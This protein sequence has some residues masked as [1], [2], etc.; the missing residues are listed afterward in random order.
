MKKIDR[1]IVGK[2][3]STFI[4]M[5]GMVIALTVLVDLVEKIDDFIDRQVSAKD[6]IFGYYAN[7]IPYYA[8]LLA[9]VCIFLSVIFFTSRLASRTEIV[10]MLSAG[11]S[12]YRLLVPYL[13]VSCFLAMLSFYFKAY[14][15]PISALKRIEFEYTIEDKK[16]VSSNRNIHKKVAHD[17]YL[18]INYYNED[19]KEG[20]NFTLERMDGGELVEKIHA[21]QIKWVDSTQHWELKRVTIRDVSEG[22]FKVNII[23]SLDTTLLLTPDDIFIIE[24]KE[25]TL[26][27]PELFR[28]IE[29]EELRGS[30]ILRELYIERHRRFADPIAIIILMLIGFAMSSRK[31]RGGTALQIG[32]GLIICFCYIVLLLAGEAISGGRYAP[33]MAVWVPNIIFAGISIWLLRVVPK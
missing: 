10:P 30:D 14:T 5:M 11:I 13:L 3:I 19:R 6:V 31:T 29:L 26:T 27:L 1:Y 2:Y 20:H 18:Y 4:F 15:V 28:Y 33:W 22:K 21:N 17:T 24:H 23:P 16:R 32:L 25:Q 8:N 12:F 7:F 9:P